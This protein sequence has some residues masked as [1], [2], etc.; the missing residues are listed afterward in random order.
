MHH[1]TASWGPQSPLKANNTDLRSD[2]QDLPGLQDAGLEA[3]C[4]GHQLPHATKDPLD[5][6]TWSSQMTNMLCLS[7]SSSERRKEEFSQWEPAHTDQELRV[8]PPAD[9]SS[10]PLP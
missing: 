6:G 4:W 7:T 3:I 9:A 2:L 8:Q 10:Q 5:A 1:V